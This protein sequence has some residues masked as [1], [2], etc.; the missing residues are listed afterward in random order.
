MSESIMYG[1]TE[2]GSRHA[3]VSRMSGCLPVRCHPATHTGRERN[4][5][6]HTLG[7]RHPVRAADRGDNR[8]LD[9]PGTTRV[10][11]R[12]QLLRAR[13]GAGAVGSITESDHGIDGRERSGDSGDKGREEVAARIHL[14][15]LCARHCQS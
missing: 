1:G 12:H 4:P 13:R 5:E 10:A 7:G 2:I 3:P 14:S 6:A 8:A 11:S 15:D 9:R